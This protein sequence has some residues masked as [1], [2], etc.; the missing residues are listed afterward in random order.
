[1]LRKR[2]RKNEWKKELFCNKIC[3]I[4]LA[5]FLSVS[6]SWWKFSQCTVSVLNIQL[7][8]SPFSLSH[9]FTSRYLSLSHYLHGSFLS[10]KPY[11][12]F[13]LSLMNTLVSSNTHTLS[14]ANAVSYTPLSNTLFDIL[15]TVSLSLSLTHSLTLSLLSSKYDSSTL[16]LSPSF[17]FSIQSEIAWSTCDEGINVFLKQNSINFGRQQPNIKVSM[18]L[19]LTKQQPFWQ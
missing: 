6:L 8:H 13:F 5:C 1:M 10:L 9:T 18:Y 14:I 17:I 19:L 7:T 16:L 15:L 3:R 12:A 4:D 2:P 11:I